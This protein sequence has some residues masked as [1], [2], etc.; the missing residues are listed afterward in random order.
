MAEKNFISSE[1]L[2]F[3]IVYGVTF[4]AFIYVLYEMLFLESQH[5]SQPLKLIVLALFGVF[6]IRK[7][8]SGMKQNK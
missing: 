7:G 6:F 1:P 2:F 4:L 5:Q 8:L 3:K